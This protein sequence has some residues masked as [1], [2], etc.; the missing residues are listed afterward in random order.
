MYNLLI[1]VLQIFRFYYRVI[2]EIF[3][4]Y[5]QSFKGCRLKDKEGEARG[6]EG[7]NEINVNEKIME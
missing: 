1:N 4:V 7:E 6:M 5:Y 2:W 3:S